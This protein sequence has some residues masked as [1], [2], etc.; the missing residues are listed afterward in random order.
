MLALDRFAGL[1][2]VCAQIDFLNSFRS[3]ASGANA[4][5]VSPAGSK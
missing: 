5:T 4:S 2:I 3:A 1:V